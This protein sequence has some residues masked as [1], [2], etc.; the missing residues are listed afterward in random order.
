MA[1]QPHTRVYPLAE[2]ARIKSTTHE[3]TAI[4]RSLDCP[5]VWSNRPDAC[6]CGAGV[7]YALRQLPKARSR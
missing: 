5:A 7:R 6:T 3:I 1:V 4:H 2:L